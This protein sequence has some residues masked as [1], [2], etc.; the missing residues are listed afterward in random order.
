LIIDIRGVL[1]LNKPETGSWIFDDG[2]V[3]CVVLPGWVELSFV[4]RKLK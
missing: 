1:G 3:V 2:V 4:A